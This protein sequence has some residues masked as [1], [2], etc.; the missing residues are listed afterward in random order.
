MRSRNIPAVTRQVATTPAVMA[1]A[2]AVLAETAPVVMVA[3]AMALVAVP[4]PGVPTEVPRPV[5]AIL[6]AVAVARL[7]VRPLAGLAPARMAGSPM[8]AAVSVAVV[9]PVAMAAM[10]AAPSRVMR[11]AA[12]AAIRTDRRIPAADPVV[13]R[14]ADMGVEAAVAHRPE[15]LLVA[16]LVEAVARRLAEAPVGVAIPQ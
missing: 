8:V 5:A 14:G 4:V 11:L 13:A 10:A 16:H 12:T 2:V 9:A 7:A 3:V 6:A 15:A 1:L